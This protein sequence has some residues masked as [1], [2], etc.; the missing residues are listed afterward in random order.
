MLNTILEIL[1]DNKAQD[2]ISIDVRQL[3]SMTD[4]MVICT[5]NSTRHV[6]AIARALSSHFKPQFEQKPHTEGENYGQWVLVDLHD[7]IV[8]VMLADMREY[9]QLEKLWQPRPNDESA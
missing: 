5:G 7:V 2:V 8:H 6:Q 1:D 4:Q 3:T 9:Y